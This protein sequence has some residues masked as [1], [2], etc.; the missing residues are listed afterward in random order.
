MA[1]LATLIEAYLAG[2]AQL[3]GAVNGMSRE[4]LVAQPVPGKMSTL[5]VVCHITDFE[6]VYAD[7]MKRVIALDNP[8]LLGADEN[9]FRAALAYQQR[10]VEEELAIVERTR[11]QMA[12]ILSTLPEAA[13]ER[14]GTHDERGPQTLEKLLTTITG[15]IGH[16]LRFIQ[17]KRQALGLK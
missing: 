14:T 13:L 8:T 5:E 2:P 11:S 16:H 9:R 7:R 17:E 15:H 1:K 10:D 3:R 4:Q 6:P 12:R